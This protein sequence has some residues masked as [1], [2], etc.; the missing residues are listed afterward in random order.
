MQDKFAVGTLFGLIANIPK[1]LLD[2]ILYTS[3]FSRFYCWHVTGGVVLSGKWLFTPEGYFIGAVIDFIFAG[4]LGVLGTYTVW[5]MRE[6]GRWLFLKAIGFSL[7]IWLFL[8]IMVVEKASMWPLL[9]GPR[10][11]YHTFLVHQLWGGV[12]AFLLAKYGREAIMGS[13]DEG[14][15]RI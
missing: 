14:T 13:S 15:P 1:M 12:F 9:T 11:A 7:F 8:C 4:F 10:H 5:L 2:I 3:G 6:R